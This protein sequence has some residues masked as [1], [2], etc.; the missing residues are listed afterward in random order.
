VSSTDHDSRVFVT[1]LKAAL[2]L[3]GLSPDFHLQIDHR[4]ED[5]AHVAK[6]AVGLSSD[7]MVIV[8]GPRA[9]ARFLLSLREGSFLGKIYGGPSMARRAFVESVGSSGEGSVFPLPASLST[10]GSFADRFSERFGRIPDYATAH[11]YDAT[12]LLIHAIRKAGLNR[13]RIRDAVAGVSIWNGV[14]GVLTWDRLG[15]NERPVQLGTLE[16]GRVVALVR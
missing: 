3:S 2:A 4:I 5:V 15:Q 1:E 10:S 14:G 6:Q 12:R 11:T 8:A 16:Q 13:A 7:A 9:S